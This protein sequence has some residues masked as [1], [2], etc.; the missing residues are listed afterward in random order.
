MQTKHCKIKRQKLPSLFMTKTVSS[1]S[2]KGLYIYT[3]DLIGAFC[4]ILHWTNKNTKI[5]GDNYGYFTRTENQICDII[6]LKDL[7]SSDFIL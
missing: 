4:I 6:R 7:S 3:Q 5:E 2:V 1:G